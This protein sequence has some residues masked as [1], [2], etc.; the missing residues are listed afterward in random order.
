MDIYTIKYWSTIYVFAFVL[1]IYPITMCVFIQS[2]RKKSIFRNMC[3][4]VL[5]LI[6]L[7]HITSRRDL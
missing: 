1:S 3:A 5:Y 7:G 6:G 4:K 2:Q